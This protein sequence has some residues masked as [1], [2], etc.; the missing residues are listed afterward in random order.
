VRSIGL[1]PSLFSIG[2]GS[3]LF[4]GLFSSHETSFGAERSAA[5]AVMAVY[6]ALEIGTPSCL[7]LSS[8][9]ALNRAHQRV[10]GREQVLLGHDREAHMTSNLVPNEVSPSDIESSGHT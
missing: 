9:P 1:P 6:L 4:W 5:V 2:L 10:H 3:F 7:P 8:G